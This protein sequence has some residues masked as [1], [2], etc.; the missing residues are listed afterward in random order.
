MHE[1]NLKLNSL[2]LF[3]QY[4]SVTYSLIYVHIKIQL[5]VYG[6]MYNDEIKIV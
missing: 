5:S 6:G 1:E 3:P 2:I 4:F